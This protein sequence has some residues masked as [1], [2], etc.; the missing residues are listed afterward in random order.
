[1]IDHLRNPADMLHTAVVDLATSLLRKYGDTA[2][3]TNPIEQTMRP[4]LQVYHIHSFPQTEALRRA[5]PPD[6]SKYTPKP[7]YNV[8]AFPVYLPLH[9]VTVVL[10]SMPDNSCEILCI[11]SY[12]KDR[13]PQERYD[14]R[15]TFPF[16]KEYTLLLPYLEQY[17]R[18][19]WPHTT[20]IQSKHLT[21]F[22]KQSKDNHC[23]AH[24]MLNLQHI[25]TLRN[26]HENIQDFLLALQE[27]SP[28]AYQPV[29]F[30]AQILEL[31]TLH[32]PKNQRPNSS[33]AATTTSNKTKTAPKKR[34]EDQHLIPT[35][36]LEVPQDD[37]YISS[38]KII[39][40]R[41][42]T[43]G[44]GNCF[45]ASVAYQ[46]KK[47]FGES[48][49][50]EFAK[51]DHKQVRTS[52]YCTTNLRQQLNPTENII[53]QDDKYPWHQQ[54]FDTT[55]AD[56]HSIRHTVNTYNICVA[57]HRNCNPPWPTQLIYPAGYD[58][59]DT[60][61]EQLQ[62][63][64]IERCAY[65]YPNTHDDSKFNH[66][67][68][69]TETTLTEIPTAPR[70]TRAVQPIHDPPTPTKNMPKQKARSTKKLRIIEGLPYTKVGIGPSLLGKDVGDGLFLFETI[71]AGHW[72]A[73]YGG[74]IITREQ[75]NASTSR[76][77]FQH[78]TNKDLYIDAQDP[79][80]GYGRYA[81]DPLDKS[82]ENLRL[83]VIPFP[84]PEDPSQP[85]QP[86]RVGYRSTKEIKKGNEGY[87]AYEGEYWANSRYPIEVRRK[88]A[89]RY[90]EYEEHI[91]HAAGEGDCKHATCTKQRLQHIQDIM[92]NNDA[93]PTPDLSCRTCTTI[94]DDQATHTEDSPQKTSTTPTSNIK[95]NATQKQQAQHNMGGK[96]KLWTSTPTLAQNKT[97]PINRRQQNITEIFATRSNKPT[98]IG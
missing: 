32:D 27:A 73:D 28:A 24:A 86:D 76:Y 33:A 3:H 82:K 63:I 47:L 54:Q 92:N 19:R 64:N 34:T 95:T 4:D 39:Y 96:Q 23:G 98:G 40:K 16:Y 55:Y 7:Q 52:M 13:P 56:E 9:F 65:G 70:T 61:R 45:Y 88:A 80:S 75:A 46:L 94:N 5:N 37:N 20:T 67:Q 77:I 6:P 21:K 18:S 97:K 53:W 29:A 15:K 79:T 8:I 59:N 48:N 10:L 57:I 43:K 72:V 81:N 26:K 44:D 78:P 85:K 74:T 14:P 58:E 36:G 12:R 50:D 83:A 41:I 69:L 90:P 11:D 31:C 93:P 71:N 30:R 89:I 84:T 42:Q 66:Y 49:P 38:N 22:P 91:L 2:F 51:I 60:A 25:V 1:M 17:A 62:T 35:I 87:M 68:P